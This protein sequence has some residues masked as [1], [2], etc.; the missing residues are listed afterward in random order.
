MLQFQ[1][2]FSGVPIFSANS[3]ITSRAFIFIADLVK[4]G[5]SGTGLFSNRHLHLNKHSAR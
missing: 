4:G 5:N 3:L 1:R 2:V